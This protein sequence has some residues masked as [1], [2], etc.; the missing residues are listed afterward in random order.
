MRIYLKNNPAKFHP[1]PI[2]KTTVPFRLLLQ[3][4][5]EQEEEQ[6]NN[7]NNN[8]NNNDN[9]KMSSDVRSVPDLKI[10]ILFSAVGI[11]VHNL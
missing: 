3:R 11:S 4:S 8:N 6:E 2:F 9:V 7:N 5:S 1:D 10:N